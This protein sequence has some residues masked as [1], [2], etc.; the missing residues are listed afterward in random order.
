MAPVQMK[1]IH[2][3]LF[4]IG[5]FVIFP[6]LNF[7]STLDPET[8][9]RSVAMGILLLPYL[10]YYLIKAVIGQ[11]PL[12]P[13]LN[14]R[15]IIFLFLYIMVSS[16]SL[17]KAVNPGDGLFDVLKQFLY[18]AVI[19]IAAQ[20][21]V[22]RR[23]NLDIMICSIN[24]SVVIFSAF[25]LFQLIHLFNESKDFNQAFVIGQSLKSSLKS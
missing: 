21:I 19:L 12:L 17:I 20:F 5:N 8:V 7:S 10:F 6:F 11:K 23:D 1:N 25:G 13:F 22:E 18:L 14:N 9:W 2:T 3:L 15:V 16:L 24:V 4:F